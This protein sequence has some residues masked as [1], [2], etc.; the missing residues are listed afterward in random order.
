MAYIKHG[1]SA[2]RARKI[3]GNWILKGF[4]SQTRVFVFC[5]K[6]NGEWLMS[7]TLE[8]QHRY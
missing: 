2:E 8:K 4:E 5:P 7:Y 6:G 3:S 1:A